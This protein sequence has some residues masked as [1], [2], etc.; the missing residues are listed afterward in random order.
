MR[1][2]FLILFLGLGLPAWSYPSGPAV[3]LGSNPVFAHG[4]NV[5]LDSNVTIFTAPS[6]QIM[7]ITDVSLGITQTARS[8]EASLMVRLKTDT[9]LVLAE[10][11][12]GMPDL[13]NHPGNTQGYSFQ[14][15]LPVQPGQALIIQTETAYRECSSAYYQV[16]YTVSGYRA[17]P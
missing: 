4:G 5:G 11:G 8:C 7:V 13:Y 2:V 10:F 17:Q 12:V 3:S 1:S 16:R 14:S 15:G 6:D 9:E